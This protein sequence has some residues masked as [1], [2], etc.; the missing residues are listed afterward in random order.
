MRN[1]NLFQSLPTFLGIKGKNVAKTL[2]GQSKVFV[3]VPP[4]T[5]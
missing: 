2:S 3:S 4:A 5:T 1:K